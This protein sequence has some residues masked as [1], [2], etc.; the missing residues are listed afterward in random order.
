MEISSVQQQLNAWSEPAPVFERSLLPHELFELVLANTEME[1]ICV[2]STN[3]TRL[4]GNH[5]FTMAVK[6]LKAFPTILLV[7]EYAGLPR[8]EMYW[9]R[10][11]GWHN[12]VVSAMMT[13]TEFLECN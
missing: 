8:Q 4:K 11:D 2:E 6:R 3:Y 9:E 13:K 1:K 5:M 7:S 10:R 12:L